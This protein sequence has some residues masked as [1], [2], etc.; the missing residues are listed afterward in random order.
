MESSDKTLTSKVIFSF[1]APDA[2][3]V[4]VDGTFNGR[5]R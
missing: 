2:V 5:D 1:H 3:R 4:C